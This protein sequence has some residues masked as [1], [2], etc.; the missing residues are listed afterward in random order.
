MTDPTPPIPPAPPTHEAVAAVLI[1]A[2]DGA[3]LLA[4]QPVSE[5]HW[6]L[7]RVDTA[8]GRL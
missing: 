1:A 2:A 4:D 8:A 3:P 7:Q 5:L 6:G